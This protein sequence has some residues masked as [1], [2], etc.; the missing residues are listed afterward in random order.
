[1][2]RLNSIFKP[3]IDLE[4]EFYDMCHVMEDYLKKEKYDE[5][6]E[7]HMGSQIND[8]AKKDNHIQNKI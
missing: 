1:M 5:V 6:Q 8:Y 7:K 2:V 3:L 4:K